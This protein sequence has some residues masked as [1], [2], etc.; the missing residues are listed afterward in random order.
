MARAVQAFGVEPLAYLRLFHGVRV[1]HVLFTEGL[2]APCASGDLL[3]VDWQRAPLT[4][5]LLR[6]LEGQAITIAREH[7]IVDARDAL[8]WREGALDTVTSLGTPIPVDPAL[9][10]A[11]QPREKTKRSLVHVALDE[12]QARAVAL[13]EQASLLVLGEAGHGKTTVALLRLARLA[14]S[15]R[16][17]GRTLDAL[18]IVPTEALA[19]LLRRAL[20]E[21]GEDVEV[22]TFDAFV[23]RE[24]RAAFRDLPRRLSAS[25]RADLQ[26]LKRDEALLPWLEARAKLPPGYVDDDEDARA[27]RTRAHAQRSDLQH[28]FGDRLLLD[29][30]IAA[31]RGSY[32]ASTARALMAHTHVQ[33]T[34]RSERTLAHVDRERLVT[35]DGRRTLDEGTPLEDAHTVDLED[36]AVLFELDRLRAS[37]LGK[38]PTEPR[39]HDV[40]ML[41]EAQ[42]FAAVELRLIGRC[43]KTEGVL[44]VAGD[45]AQQLD[46]AME[47]RPWSAVMQ[48]LGKPT[49]HAVRLALGYRCAPSVVA[50]AHRAL[51][52]EGAAI[53]VLRVASSWLKLVA[54]ASAITSLRAEDSAASIAVIARSA[55][56][57]RRF[58]SVLT[59][60]ASAR[61]TL[62]ARFG[63][64]G[65]HVTSV[66]QVRGL[67]FDYVFI[68]DADRI[69][70]PGD[71]RSRRALYL[72]IT[73]ARHGV[74]CV[75]DGE[76]TPLA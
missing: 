50:M 5:A 18:V 70:Y 51:S 29:R 37:T 19:V 33:F 74:R 76:V 65:V 17:E 34:P 73:R 8:T 23:V 32:P 75:C 30:V 31:S 64:G 39:K 38:A 41:D 28:L 16:R 43:V 62:D 48:D 59:P 12:A 36:Y 49:H 15:A 2:D 22:S 40:I 61:L 71:A 13:P 68:P 63:R 44:I 26:R 6:G 27:P 55:S 58:A 54:L 69:T 67:E 57:A 42:E 21:L 20:R 45:A 3:L 14:A 25:T 47:E 24:G 9:R 4:E 52:A 66:D 53:D 35:A 72:A 56:A 7:F 46:D 10:F 1:L 11:R 60:L